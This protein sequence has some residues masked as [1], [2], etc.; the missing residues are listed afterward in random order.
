MQ[1]VKNNA[2]TQDI[3]SLMQRSDIVAI[4]F[5]EYFEARSTT[6][7]DHSFINVTPQQSMLLKQWDNFILSNRQVINLIVSMESL[8]DAK[9]MS[10]YWYREVIQLGKTY[11]MVDEVNDQIYNNASILLNNIDTGNLS[12]LERT[13]ITTFT[14]VAKYQRS[15]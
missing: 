9:D 13:F 6:N 12:Q 3:F 11:Y 4:E 5:T 10:I 2:R 1:R 7:T 15:E 8:E 14:N